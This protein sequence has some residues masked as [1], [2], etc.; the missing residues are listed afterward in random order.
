MWSWRIVI[1]FFLLLRQI[2]VERG[3]AAIETFKKQMWCNCCVSIFPPS[4]GIH[5]YCRPYWGDDHNSKR[6]DSKPAVWC[7][8]TIR[9]TNLREGKSGKKTIE[10]NIFNFFHDFCKH[11]THQYTNSLNSTSSSCG[12]NLT[13]NLVMGLGHIKRNPPVLF[14]GQTHGFSIL[15]TILW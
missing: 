13:L 12:P 15:P 5:M 10:L 6:K 11:K 7:L 1:K 9:R 3:C 8:K 4:V 14:T 2:H